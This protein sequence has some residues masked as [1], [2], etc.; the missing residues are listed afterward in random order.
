MQTSAPKDDVRLSP[1]AITVLEKRY[2][3]KGADGKPTEQPADLFM[4]V[5]NTVAEADKK[6][7]ASDGA[8]DALADE[9]FKLMAHRLFL[10]NS[11]TL[12]NAGRP[13][14]QLSACFVLRRSTCQ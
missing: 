11:P 6:Y 2:L 5:A 14:S 3:V 13:L 4:R 9:F 8:V 7:G 10:P 12:M 1:N